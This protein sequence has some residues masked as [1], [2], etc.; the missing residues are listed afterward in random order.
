MRWTLLGV[1][2]VGGGCLVDANT[3]IVPSDYRTPARLLEDLTGRGLYQVEGLV[4]DDRR[5]V[6]PLGTT[7]C[8]SMSG[9]RVPIP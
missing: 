7:R 8:L 5:F 9:R 3:S 1:V 4:V 6:H 2:L